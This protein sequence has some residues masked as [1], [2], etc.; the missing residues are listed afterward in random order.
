MLSYMP[1]KSA[2]HEFVTVTPDGIR[3]RGNTHH[4]LNGLVKWFKEH[5]RDA[6]PGSTPSSSMDT[7]AGMNQHL[8]IHFVTSHNHN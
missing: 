4:S 5:Y 8:R 1:R 7:P 2:K 6:M 3:Y